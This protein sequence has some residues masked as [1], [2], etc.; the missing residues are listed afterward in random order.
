MV[1]RNPMSGQ[2][3]MS[4]TEGLGRSARDVSS[5]GLNFPSPPPQMRHF[6]RLT[7][8]VGW[9]YSSKCEK[10]TEHLCPDKESFDPHFALHFYIMFH[11]PGWLIIVGVIR[12]A[13][14]ANRSCFPSLI[15]TSNLCSPAQTF[16]TV[17]ATENALP[18]RKRE[19][20]EMTRTS[21]KW[22]TGKN[23]SNDLLM[24]SAMSSNSGPAE[25]GDSG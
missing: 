25:L 3:R 24:A 7:G 11:V 20:S 6:S 14:L 10:E 12:D 9:N 23:A 18:I 19:A 8:S 2:K 1:V 22:S 15:K 16:V 13:A 5:A 4:P 17:V 21:G